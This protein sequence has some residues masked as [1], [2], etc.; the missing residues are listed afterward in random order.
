MH[1][2]QWID[3]IKMW[4]L[5]RLLQT[6][7]IKA[8]G[9]NFCLKLHCNRESIRREGIENSFAKNN[10]FSFLTIDKNWATDRLESLKTYGI[11]IGVT[12]NYINLFSILSN[13][14]IVRNSFVFV[15]SVTETCH[16]FTFDLSHGLT[17]IIDNFR[18]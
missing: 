11:K 16:H 3:A 7:A 17:F 10:W 13:A 9:K 5:Q 14:R 12:D 15:T 2:F 4:N 1:R 18:M 6:Y 8:N